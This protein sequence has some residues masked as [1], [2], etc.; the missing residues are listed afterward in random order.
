MQG[1]WVLLVVALLRGMVAV[2]GA[3]REVVV[4][5]VAATGTGLVPMIVLTGLGDQHGMK[6]AAAAATARG[7][8]HMIAP[9]EAGG[10][11]P[12]TIATEKI[13]KLSSGDLC[14]GTQE[15]FSL[16]YVNFLSRSWTVVEEFLPFISWSL[17]LGL[18][19]F[20][21]FFPIALAI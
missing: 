15:L 13:E 12:S 5:A 19:S 3:M 16:Q 9:A 8:A 18:F 2:L 21:F 14:C 20:F 4:A 6:G 17:L 7:L 10:R 1:M 11:Q